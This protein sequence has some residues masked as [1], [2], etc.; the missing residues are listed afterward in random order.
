MQILLLPVTVALRIK[1]LAFKEDR[2]KDF[3]RGMKANQA[4]QRLYDL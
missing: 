2:E 3:G 1:F 4:H